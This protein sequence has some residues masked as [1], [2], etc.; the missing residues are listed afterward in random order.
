MKKLKQL[1]IFSSVLIVMSSCDKG[2]EDLNKDPYAMTSI[3][4]GF[5]FT[6]A[7]RNTNAGSWEG[8]QTIVQQFVNVYNL[9]ATQ[10]FNF[11][12]YADN[13][14]NPRW[15]GSYPSSL[16]N[17]EQVIHLTKDDASRSNLYN[18]ARI[19]KSYIYMTLVDTYGG[20]P[21]TDASKAFIGGVFYPKYDRDSDIY[22]SL[23]NEIKSATAALDAS[24]EFVREDLFFGDRG[25]VGPQIAQWKKVGNSL[26][27]RLGMRYSKVDQA[28][29]RAIVQ[30][31]F[32]GGVMDS[33]TD[34]VVIK[35]T[36]VA[37]QNNPL[38]NGPRTINPYY[39]YLAEPLVSHLKNNKDPRLKYIAGKYSAPQAPLNIRPDTTSAKQVGFPIGYDS[40]TI[41]Q[42]SD[43]Q[44]VQGGGFNYSQLNY[45]VFGSATAPIYFVSTA[46][47]KLLLAEA[48][49]RGWLSGGLTAKE[50]YEAGIKASMDEYST[51]PNV[52]SPA[53]STAAYNSYINQP[54]IAFSSDKALDLINTQYW[55]VCL[56]NGAESFANFRRS[57][58]P[59]LAPNLYNNS[60]EGGFVRRMVYPVNEQSVNSAN[61]LEAIE[62][63]NKGDGMLSRVFWDAQ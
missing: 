23:Y 5:L 26:L 31:A 41:T 42:K 17:L 30:E 37:G 40:N 58:Y 46:Q 24:K 19:W 52:P 51:Y 25:T 6:G 44:G 32:A 63:L 39:Y 34:N 29:A 18:M 10:A 35:Y 33:N 47:T 9:G 27:L 49:H 4:P 3:N 11:N 13:F 21:Y 50:Y 20:L 45:D 57:G 38:N 55:V 60:L 7:Q 16:K 54:G 12:N 56:G 48:A 62:R 36:S 22:E 15:N 28:K 53:V 61:Y 8:E 59:A 14:N 2:F 43:Y 1:L